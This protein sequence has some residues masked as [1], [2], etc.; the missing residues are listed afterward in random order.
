MNRT[1]QVHLGEAGGPLGA[2][3]HDAQ[4]ARENAAFSYD[5]AWLSAPGRFAIDPPPPAPGPRPDRRA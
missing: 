3:R 1:L 4:G 2:L 5:P